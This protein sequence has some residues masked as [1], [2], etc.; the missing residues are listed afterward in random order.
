MDF[1]ASILVIM[2]IFW[3]MFLVLKWSFF[4][5]VQELLRERGETIDTARA[6]HQAATAE[7]DSRIEAER[8]KL[9]AIR[10]EAAARRD[11]LRKEGEDA[12]RQMLE[13][14]SA[15]TEERI[16]AATEELEATVARERETLETRAR[17]IADQMTDRLLEKS[18]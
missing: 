11:G 13:E 15:A 16:A 17:E 8:K 10:A 14:T 7:L 3:T 5:P 12:R 2:G 18:A 1:D 6:E 4:G 9:N